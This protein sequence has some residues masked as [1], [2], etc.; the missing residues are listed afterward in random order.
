MRFSLDAISS[1]S[2]VPL[3]AAT[4]LGFVFSAAAFL[5]I[6]VAIGM[7]DRRAVRARA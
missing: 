2:Q 6:P 7:Q 1:F 4:V 3:Q 5:A